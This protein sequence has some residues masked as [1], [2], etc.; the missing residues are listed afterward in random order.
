M[1]VG[2]A[3]GGDD[4]RRRAWRRG[5]VGTSTITATSAAVSG[6]DDAD[7]DGGDAVVDRGDAGEPVDAAGTT[8]QFTATGTYSDNTTQNLTAA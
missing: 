2:N 4:Q 3:G 7:G 6:H 8:Q 1:D 5:T